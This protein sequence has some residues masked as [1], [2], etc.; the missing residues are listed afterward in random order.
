MKRTIKI[1][2]PAII[3]LLYYTGCSNDNGGGTTDPFGTGGTS[4]QTSS[5]AWT[6]GHRQ[7]DQGGIVFTA[8]PSVAVTVTQVTCSLPEQNYQDPLQGDGTTVFQ[9]GQFYDLEE[10]TGV[11]SGQKWTFQFQGKIG[12]TQGQNYNVTSNYTVP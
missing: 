3:F 8:K 6:M 9:P 10:Y 12:N 5:V 1:L 2:I 7:G 11:A 4:G